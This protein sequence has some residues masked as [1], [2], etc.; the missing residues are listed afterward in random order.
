MTETLQF[1][2]LGQAGDRDP[3]VIMSVDLVCERVGNDWMVVA[4]PKTL[5]FRAEVPTVVWDLRITTPDVVRLEFGIYSVAVVPR[6]LVLPMEMVPG[7]TLTAWIPPRAFQVGEE[8]P[9]DEGAWWV[10][11]INDRSDGSA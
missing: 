6:G 9:V 7:S 2:V 8:R 5:T 10:E 11:P 1:Q 3:G 4:G